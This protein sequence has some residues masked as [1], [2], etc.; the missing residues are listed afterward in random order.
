MRRRII[1]LLQ[2]LPLPGW[3][4]GAL[5]QGKQQSSCLILCLLT[6]GSIGGRC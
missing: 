4:R 5:R 1:V 2:S 3:T 6:G